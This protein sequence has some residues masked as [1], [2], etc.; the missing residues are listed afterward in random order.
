VNVVI[1]LKLSVGLSTN[2]S[3]RLR[4]I[5]VH[6]SG[7]P[8]TSSVSTV[9]LRDVGSV[10]TAIA[11]I[12]GACL[13]QKRVYVRKFKHKG[14]KFTVQLF[15]GWF[16]STDPELSN[17]NVRGPTTK[18]PKDVFAPVR[19]QRRLGFMNLCSR[20]PIVNGD[21]QVP[22]REVY[23]LLHNYNVTYWKPTNTQKTLSSGG[24]ITQQCSFIDFATRDE[25]KDAQNTFDG[26][27]YNGHKLQVR[28]WQIPRKFLGASWD[29]GRGGEHFSGQRDQGSAV[30]TNYE[31]VRL[32]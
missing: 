16:A 30:G 29:T 25:A 18:P 2:F 13:F 5:M 12:N 28:P 31:E 3:F 26:Q 22:A 8:K 7:A 10:D 23:S 4:I 11:E 27:M 19:E 1:I 20:D 6:D 9:I 14:S 17:A 21:N 15:W 32:S 24:K